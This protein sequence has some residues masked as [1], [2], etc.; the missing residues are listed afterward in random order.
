V[1]AEP[2]T[3]LPAS[4]LPEAGLPASGLPERGLP[5]SGLPER[6]LSEAG[7]P[8]RGLSEAVR[9]A[10]RPSSS[11]PASPRAGAPTTGSDFAR[12]GF[13]LCPSLID[14]ATLAGLR[15]AVEAVH[16]AVVAEA[17]R[18]PIERV[19]GLRY[20][21]LL[22]S[23]VKWEWDEASREIRS[24][25]PVAHLDPRIDALLDDPRLVEPAAKR[26]GVR[27]LSLFTDKLNFKRPGG[28]P[29]PWHQDAPYWAFGCGHLDRLASLQVYL[30]DATVESGCLWVIPGSHRHGVLPGL[31]DRGVLGRLYTDL[32]RVESDGVALA[33]PIPLEAPAGSV[34]FF[35]GFIVHGSQRNRGAHSR[36][37]LV[38]TYQPAGH[39]R[40]GDRPERPIAR[41]R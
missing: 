31:S 4:G 14:A 41:S 25:E 12:D 21:T 13:E 26:L 1:S 17:D 7:L 8:E 37:A 3:A 11:A 6:G 29:F 30:D 28:S 24:M 22:Q 40:W 39:P 9:P 16:A 15:E 19:D 5:A 27:E 34:I 20:Q 18:Q 23:R 2:H 33:E 36:R 35:D 10:A 38:L 32:R